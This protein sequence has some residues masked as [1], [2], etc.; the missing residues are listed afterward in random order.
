MAQ[1]STLWSMAFDLRSCAA[2][3]TTREAAQ[4]K[5]VNLQKFD[6]GCASAVKMLDINAR[7]GGDATPFFT[8]YSDAANQKLLRQNKR[9]PA[10]IQD[11]MAEYPEKHTRCLE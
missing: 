8:D 10:W 11:V 3:L 7:V 4:R 1:A 2:Y 6:P 9:L 5:Q